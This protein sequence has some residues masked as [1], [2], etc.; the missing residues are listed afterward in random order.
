MGASL[1]AVGERKLRALAAAL[2]LSE[3]LSAQ[4]LDVF[5]LMSGVWGDWEVGDSPRW[6]N[7]ISDDGTPFEFSASFDGGAPRLRMLV[8][9]QSERISRISSWEA[10]IALG[11]RLK[12]RGR[13]D[14]DLF[15]RVRDLFVPHTGAQGR[16]SLW[17]AAVIEEG[18]PV[19]FKAYLNPCLFGLGSA[20]YVVE[21]ALHR[22]GFAQAWSFVKDRLASDPSAEIRYFSVDLVE[23]DSARVKVYLGCSDSA[24]AVDRLIAGAHNIQPNDAQ[25]WLAA[26]TASQ[27]PFV[28]RPILSCFSFRREQRTPDVT[29]HVPIRC[30]VKHDA[31][32]LTRV[33]ALLTPADADRLSAALNAVSERPLNVGR[34]LLTYASLRRE[35]DATRVTVYLAPEAYSITSRRPSVPPAS[36]FRSG[37]HKTS[38]RTEHDSSHMADAQSL[39]AR[40]C[41][42]LSAQPLFR[43]LA[44]QGTI[45]QAERLASHLSLFVLW[46][47]DL[48]RFAQERATDPTVATRLAERSQLA[49]VRAAR[50]RA[51]LGAIGLLPTSLSLYTEEHSLIR[52]VAFARVADVIS[53]EEDCVRLGMVLSVSA[54]CE[55]L[56]TAGFAF[57]KQAMAAQGPA[58]PPQVTGVPEPQ[59]EQ[60]ASR[61]SVGVDCIEP[62]IDPQL[63]QINMPDA[64]ASEL[65]ATINRCFESVLRVVASIDSVTFGT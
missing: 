1:G 64:V 30:Y 65:F 16:F 2:H 53:T 3:A 60:H 19:L 9:S 59:A 62:N 8:E 48:F 24:T 4:A 37:V 49:A 55:Q 45:A 52:E 7:D 35:G 51:D 41:Q 15:E 23:R 63:S 25:H 5:A 56:L 29:V 6:P 54:I 10:G 34:G 21:Q 42:L 36:D 43:H 44:C 12:A 57:A 18:Q 26:L 22:L 33:S 11:E 28:A 40:N 31:E 13:A 17:H 14:L 38:P 27:G 58:L 20:P 50:F 46:L 39:I 47:G 61:G 32:A